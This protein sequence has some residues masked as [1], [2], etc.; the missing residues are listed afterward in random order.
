MF[1]K[2]YVKNERKD[3]RFANRPP[4]ASHKSSSLRGSEATEAIPLNNG[5]ASAYGLAMTYLYVIS[6]PNISQNNISS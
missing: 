5:I 3:G 4:A 6:L 1:F 2:G